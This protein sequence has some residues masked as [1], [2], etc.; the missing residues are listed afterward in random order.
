LTI[1]GV[2]PAAGRATRLQPLEGSKEVLGVLGRPVMDYLAERM[3]EGG[4]TE[5]RVVTRPHKTDVI[6]Q[7]DVIGATVVLA[8]PKTVSESFYA[9]MAG[10]ADDDVVLIGFP[11]TIWEPLDG[12]RTLVE[13][14]HDGWNAALGLFRPSSTDLARSDVVTFEPNGRILRIDVKP[15]APTSTWI[16]GCAAATSATM[17]G[18]TR[19]EWPGSYFDLLCS[20]GHEILGVRLSDTWLDIGTRE[21]L[22]RAPG[23][24][25]APGVHES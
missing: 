23:L 24:R 19:T 6:A 13:A 3:R 4:C 2:I 22:R 7:C 14:V 15:S 5:L 17:A 16:W 8:E 21:A 25:P 18:L 11:D 10:L 12:Y 20:E 1:V 9:G